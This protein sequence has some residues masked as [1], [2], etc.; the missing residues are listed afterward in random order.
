MA[1]KDLE[2]VADYIARDSPRRAVSFVDELR[3][4]CDAI[5]HSPPAFQRQPALGPAVRRAVHRRYSIFYSVL[6]HEIRIERIL[7]GARDVA[8]DDFEE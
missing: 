6:A 2:E 4:A 3:R 5:V 7:H 8:A 1:E